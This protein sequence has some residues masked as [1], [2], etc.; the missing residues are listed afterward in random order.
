MHFYKVDTQT[1]RDLALRFRVLS[2]PTLLYMKRGT[3]LHRSTGYVDAGE[4]AAAVEQ[5]K[6]A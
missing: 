6:N 2:I 1:Q 4:L 3:V 5:Y